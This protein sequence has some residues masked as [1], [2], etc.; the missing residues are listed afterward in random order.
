MKTFTIKSKEDIQ[1]LEDSLESM[2]ISYE[3]EDEHTLVVQLLPE[4][5]DSFYIF[6]AYI[7]SASKLSNINEFLLNKSHEEEDSLF[8]QYLQESKEVLLEYKYFV[9]L[10]YLKIMDYFT[11]NDTIQLEAFQNFNMRGFK[12]EAT[13][14]IEKAKVT[15]DD[16]R[17]EEAFMDQAFSD[18][19]EM[20][21]QSEMIRFEDFS[22]IHVSQKGDKLYFH[23]KNNEELN[24]EFMN[25][26]LGIMIDFSQ[27]EDVTEIEKQVVEAIF[28]AN[29]FAPTT[30][31]I[32]ESV[33]DEACEHFED[34]QIILE[35]MNDD[36]IQIV[37]VRDED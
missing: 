14:I 22:E 28:Y 12:E 25:N 13:E 37:F 2:D 33:C 1:F 36:S 11:E 5:E 3:F 29:L 6:L 18:L 8:A 23:N 4:Q 20:I 34:E 7:L 19:R 15:E 30:L 24:R 21:K 17:N 32:H 10:T 9:G 31:V 35:E 26:H 16:L 27:E